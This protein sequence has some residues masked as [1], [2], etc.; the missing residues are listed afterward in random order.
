[1]VSALRSPAESFGPVRETV[2]PAS[3][4]ELP[5]MLDLETGRILP[6]IPYENFKFRA[7]AIMN[8]IRSKGL[9]ISCNVWPNGATCVTYDMCIVAVAGKCWDE[10]TEEEILG[11]PALAPKAHSPR[12]LLVVAQNRSDTY[13]FRTGE[14]TSGIL[15]IAGTCADR[16]GVKILYRLINSPKSATQV[17]PVW[18]MPPA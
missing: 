15:R 8:W 12:R 6:Q 9:D 2:L 13:I 17:A 7:P 10:I 4:T 3:K 5:E 14:G 1:V 11:N 16:R 18:N